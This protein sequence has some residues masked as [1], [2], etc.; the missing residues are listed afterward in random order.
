[1]SEKSQ[2]KQKESIKEQNSRLYWKQRDEMETKLVNKW[3]KKPRRSKDRQD[4][5]RRGK[6]PQK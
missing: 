5:T 1:M 4:E 3:S 6:K 2:Q